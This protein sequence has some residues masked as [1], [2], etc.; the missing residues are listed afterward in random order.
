MSW[1][2]VERLRQRFPEVEPFPREGGGPPAEA[3][4]PA[5]TAGT[6]TPQPPPAAPPTRLPPKR[7]EAKAPVYMTPG[8]WIP[9]ER[10]TGICRFVAA[11]PAF[12]LDYLSFVTGVDYP[13][14]KRI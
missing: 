12:A 2:L 8:A 1:D 3:A 6:G 13:E 9:V 14:Q 7:E 5:A 4:P 11:D 10:L